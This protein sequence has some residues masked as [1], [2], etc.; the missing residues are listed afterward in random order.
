MATDTNAELQTSVASWLQRDD[1]NA[2][3]PQFI[4]FATSWFTRRLRVPQME[5]LAQTTIT[6]EWTALPVD[7]VA[8]RY[9]ELANGTRLR[10]MVPEEFAIQVKRQALANTDTPIYMIGDMSLRIYPT[11]T[12]TAVEILYYKKIPQLVN[13]NDTNWLLTS[14]PDA[15]LACALWRGFDFIR[16]NEN[17]MKWRTETEL[18]ARDIQRFGKNLETGAA[19]M[20]VKAV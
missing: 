9:I 17:A 4:E 12:N 15:Y 7:F 20:A 14:F 3:I 11:Q 19:S 18:Q 6:A 16:D 8:V 10:H 13:A 5:Q 2:Q 1:L